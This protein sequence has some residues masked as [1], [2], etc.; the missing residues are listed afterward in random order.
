MDTRPRGFDDGYFKGR[1]SQHFFDKLR[2]EDQFKFALIVFGSGDWVE[3]NAAGY[4]SECARKQMLCGAWYYPY[5]HLK[6]KY[7]VDTWL[8]APKAPWGP[9]W[10]DYE[11]SKRYGTIPSATQVAELCDR[12]ERVDGRKTGIYSR[13]ELIDRYFNTLPDAWFDRP[14]WLAQY[15]WD[16]SVEDRR[17]IILPNRVKRENVWIHQ[18]ADKGAPPPGYTPLARS[19]DWD[20]WIGER[21]LPNP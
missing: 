5:R 6:P 13:K 20:R 16:R 8:K 14:F 21:E 19:Q 15:G 4:M 11:R 7:L 12:F 2:P 9:R 3:P 17:E 1:F 10:I 18:T